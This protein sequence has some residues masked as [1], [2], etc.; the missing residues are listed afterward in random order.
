[1]LFFSNLNQSNIQS[2]CFLVND[3]DVVLH[4]LQ[5]TR[6]YQTRLQ[7]SKRLSYYRL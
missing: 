7:L 5:L 4:T 3:R 1:M 2:C 6:C